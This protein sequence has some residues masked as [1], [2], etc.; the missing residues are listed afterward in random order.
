M[1]E[2][3]FEAAGKQG[4]AGK[5]KSSQ[6]KTDGIA[7]KK[8]EPNSVDPE[9]N[10]MLDKMKFMKEDLENQLSSV[11]Q[12][13]KE[14]KVNVSLLVESANALTTSQLEK[15][16]EQ[17]KLLADKINAVIPAE[18]CLKKPMKSKEKLTQER[19]GKMRGARNNWI[20]VR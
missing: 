8:N 14:S 11:Y 15:M 5:D 6:G 9:I 2:N 18:S 16:R 10:D 17:E 1:D 20:P 7:S 19:Q 13:G 4:K 3:I 12:K